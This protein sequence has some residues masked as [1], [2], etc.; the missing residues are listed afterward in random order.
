MQSQRTAL[1]RTG[2]DEEC[3][4]GLGANASCEPVG[5]QP[6]GGA[7]YSAWVYQQWCTH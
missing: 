1:M 3:E 4:D 7:R 2:T 5:K 6:P